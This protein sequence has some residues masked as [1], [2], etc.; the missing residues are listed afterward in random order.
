MCIL[1]KFQ[2]FNLILSEYQSKSQ[3][4]TFKLA[5]WKR[6]A[7]RLET[8]RPTYILRLKDLAYRPICNILCACVRACV[9]Q[10]DLT[11]SCYLSVVILTRVQHLS[12]QSMCTLTKCHAPLISSCQQLYAYN[13]LVYRVSRSGFLR[14]RPSTQYL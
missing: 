10:F 5:Q 13:S 6:L 11:S 1:F 8:R 4:V 14:A 2:F 3:L 12:I 9:R 7:F